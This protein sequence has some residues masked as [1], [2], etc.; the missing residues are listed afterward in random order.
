MSFWKFIMLIFSK[1]MSSI[2]PEKRR[3]ESGWLRR[4]GKSEVDFN[5]R[6]TSEPLISLMRL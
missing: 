3:E 2:S 4:R 5:G 6:M 1:E